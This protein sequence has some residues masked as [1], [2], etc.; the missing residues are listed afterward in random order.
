MGN[1]MDFS[2]DAFSLKGKVAMVTGANQGLGMAY[3]VAFA[4]A[5]ADLFIPH[6]TDDVSEIKQMI[7]S[8]GRKVKFLQGDL[9][10]KDYMDRVVAACIQ[11][12]GK[13]DILVNNA[14]ASR[15]GEFLDYPESA[16]EMTIELNL[17]AVYHLSHRVVKEMVKQNSG[18]I[19]NVGSALSFTADKKCPP[20]P[21]SKH[22]ILGLTKVFANECG[23]YN[24][25]TNA[26]CPGFFA[27]E[28]NKE[29][30]EDAAFYNKITNR[31]PA[32]RWG[33]LDDLMGTVVFLASSASNYINGWYI[34]LDGGFT[35]TL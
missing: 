21:T 12:Y 9:R 1:I 22:A 5:G 18:K 4:K 31:I 34:S 27:T 3:A 28:I 29:L 15:F 24:I 20:Y 8:L 16:W 17:N 7:E 23:Q 30:R 25:Q 10:D 26:I 35:T 19:I 33:E 6:F 14:G 2:M 32:G 11:E 13:I